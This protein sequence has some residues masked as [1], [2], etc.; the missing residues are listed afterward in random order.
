MGCISGSGQ[1]VIHSDVAPTLD[2]C[3]ILV[4]KTNRFDF[5]TKKELMVALVQ[6]TAMN[7]PGIMAKLMQKTA[8]VGGYVYPMAWD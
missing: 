3:R 8:T 7:L 6:G 2:Y 4:S 5:I 1:L